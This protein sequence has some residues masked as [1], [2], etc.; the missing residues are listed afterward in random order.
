ME[1]LYRLPYWQRI[2]IL[3]VFPLAIM[4]YIWFLFLSP[5]MEE[6]KKLTDEKSR[7]QADVQSIQRSMNPR[8]IEGLKSKEEETKKLLEE[9]ERELTA[10]VGNIPREK[11]I[12]VVLKQVGVL[13]RKSGLVI[14]NLRM[15]PQQEMMYTLETSGSERFVKEVQKQQQQPNKGPQVEGIEYLRSELRISLLGRYE[16]FK[17]FIEHMA[18]GGFVSYPSSISFTQAEG[19]KLKGDMSLYLLLSKEEGK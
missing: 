7:V 6:V 5:T 8:I 11:D 13:V 15:E 9:K 12:G 10:I 19:G 2:V 17:K 18:E 16:N 4:G 14:I 1:V 3:L